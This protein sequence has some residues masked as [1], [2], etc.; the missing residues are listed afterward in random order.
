M[1][2]NPDYAPDRVAR[3]DRYVT[4]AGSTPMP[5]R[6]LVSTAVLVG[7][8]ILLFLFLLATDTALSV[9]HYLK[10]TPA[11]LRLAYFAIAILLP[12]ARLTATAQGA[13]AWYATDV[14]GQMAQTWFARGKS[15]GAGGLREV[16][17]SVLASLD[18]DALLRQAREE[19]GARIV[20]AGR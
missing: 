7:A 4:P 18:R 11:W 3:F 12:L 1:R 10:E 9:W 19:L 20:R 16:A 14:T 6:L 17:A 8:L 5:L 13:L 2:V 15:R